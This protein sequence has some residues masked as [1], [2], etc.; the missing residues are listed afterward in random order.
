MDRALRGGLP[1]ARGERSRGGGAVRRIAPRGPGGSLRR[2][3]PGAAGRGEV[4]TP[5]RDARE[6]IPALRCACDR[7]LLLGALMLP[8]TGASRLRPGCARSAIS[9]AA[10]R[11]FAPADDRGRTGDGRRRIRWRARAAR[12]RSRSGGLARR[13]EMY[14]TPRVSATCRRRSAGGARQCRGDR[15]RQAD[16]RQQ[17]RPG[18]SRTCRP[19]PRCCRAAAAARPRSGAADWATAERWPSSEND[20]GNLYA[21]TGRRS[22]AAAAYDEAMANADRGSGRNA[23]GGGRNQ[24][25]AA[26]ARPRRHGNRDIGLLARAVGRL[27]RLPPSYSQGMGL[28]SAGAA[29][30]RTRAARRDSRAGRAAFAAAADGERRCTMPRL[31]SLAQGSL[32]RLYAAQRPHRGSLAVPPNGRCSTPRRRRRRNCRSAGIGSRRASRASRARPISRCASYRRAVAGLQSVRQDIPVEYRDGRSSYRVT[33]G[34][35]YREFSDLLLRR[36]AA[37]PGR[38]PR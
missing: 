21:Q 12:P 3:P 33:F 30:W 23:G 2:V 28:V 29:R 35:L 6:M 7:A 11:R 31:L 19:A 27:E 15:Q 14:R 9:T 37:D 4:G 5:D 24:Y 17:R 20:L 16:R 34:P 36:A 13:G 10:R 26:G 18:Q 38:W 8:A 25:G 32:G 1:G 22:E